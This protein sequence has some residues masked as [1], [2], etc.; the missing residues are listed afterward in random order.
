MLFLAKAEHGLELPERMPVD[1]AAEVDALLE[2][3]DAVAS[4]KELRLVREGTA[5]AEGDRLMI[6]RAIANLLSNAIRHTARGEIV[7]ISLDKDPIGG[8]RVIV[9]NPGPDIPSEH[10]S[11]IFDRF[12]RVDPARAD[13][14]GGSGLGLAITRAIVAAHHGSIDV[15]STQ[16]RTTFTVSLPASFITRL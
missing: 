8:A 9:E 1:L 12:Y 10:L 2:F 7:T 4:A 3:F 14:G 16:G 6:R 11:R 15:V 13:T 5:V